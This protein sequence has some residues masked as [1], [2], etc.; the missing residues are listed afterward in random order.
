MW[1]PETLGV[2]VADW[3]VVAVVAV[4]ATLGIVPELVVAVVPEATRLVC[5]LRMAWSH[6]ANCEPPPKPEIADMGL[7][8]VLGFTAVQ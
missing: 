7:L 4:V 5:F 3:A 6:W 1:V 8:S 2:C